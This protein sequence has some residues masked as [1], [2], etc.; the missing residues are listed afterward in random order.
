ME[1]KKIAFVV[2]QE[3]W[4]KMFLSKHHYSIELTKIGYEV[5]FI[6]PPEGS[7]KWK[8]SRFFIEQTQYENLK[9]VTQNFNI[10]S[11][12]K[13]HSRKL[14]HFFI[15]FHLK[16]LI[17]LIGVPNL[18]LSFDLGNNFPF[19][20]FSKETIKIFFPADFPR[21]KDAISS[22][23]G[24][25][26]IVS[27]AQ[28][29]INNY[30]FKDTNKLLIH[31]GLAEQ[32]I[33]A[34]PLTYRVRTLEKRVGISGNF[35]R[36]EID[37]EIL[38]SLIELN[39]TVIFECFGSFENNNN[40][41]GGG[42]DEYTVR[43]VKKLQS[44]KNV[45]MHGPISS[46]ELAREFHRMDIF[47]ICYDVQKDQSRG[48]N[49]HKVMEYLAYGRPIISNNITRY[50]SNEYL[51]MVKSRTSNQELLEIMSEVLNNLPHYDDIEL[52]KSKIDFA[53]SNSYKNNLMAILNHFQIDY[54]FLTN[55]P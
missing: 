22:A 24:A 12:L 13:F 11:N 2:S 47:L 40:N 32:F 17:K 35:L 33:N 34:E 43:F 37:R 9:V 18:I 25:N 31:H 39:S 44:L 20:H 6:C 19:N 55:L 23:K 16:K 14:F 38:L 1:A 41:L 7:W 54:P 42:N 3:K 27:V 26:L 36:P 50:N 45:I 29:I 21:N 8:T 10:P 51:I 30:P 53:K 46:E 4:G 48:T 49:Y 52:M 15:R 28:E 5:Y